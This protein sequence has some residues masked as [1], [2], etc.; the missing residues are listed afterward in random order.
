MVSRCLAPGAG[1]FFTRL[2]AGGGRLRVFLYRLPESGAGRSEFF[3]IDFTEGS[4]VFFLACYCT[5]P[6]TASVT[7]VATVTTATAYGKLNGD[8]I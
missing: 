3:Y 6:V 7:T 1:S 2:S 5:A 4:G 8:S